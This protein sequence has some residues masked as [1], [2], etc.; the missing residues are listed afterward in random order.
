M[1]NYRRD[2]PVRY[3]KVYTKQELAAFAEP[4]LPDFYGDVCGKAHWG[5]GS[6]WRKDADE[7]KLRV[8]GCHLN[9]A[10]E[11]LQGCVWVAALFGVDVTAC[12][13][14]PDF[15]PEDRAALMRRAAMAAV[16]AAK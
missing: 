1:Q 14:R 10:G 3:A 6:S 5:K 13:Y 2:L 9:P 4:R 7:R 8:D 12:P 16:R 11:Y 15:V